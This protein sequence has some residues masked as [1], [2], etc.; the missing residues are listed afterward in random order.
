SKADMEGTIEAYLERH[1]EPMPTINMRLTGTTDALIEQ[2]FIRKI[3]DCVTVENTAM[4]M[5]AVDFFINS[6]AVTQDTGDLLESNWSLEQARDN[7]LVTLWH[8]D[9]SVWDGS[10]VWAY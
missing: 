8:W 9:V 5:P 10:D 2:I 7:E 4:L 1:R 3:S 6:V